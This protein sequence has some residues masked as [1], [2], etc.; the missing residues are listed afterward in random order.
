MREILRRPPELPSELCH[1]DRRELDDC[2]IDL[3]GVSDKKQRQKLL[4]E[5]YRETTEYYRYVRTQEIQAMVNR[6]GKKGRRL[7]P[8]DLAES[9]WNSLADTEK[10]PPIIEWIKSSCSHSEMVEI[11][12]GK[13]EALGAADMFNPT[14]V[15]F[16]G[17]KENHL[18]SY[19][20]ADQA[21]LVAELA[22]LEV[23]G[24][25]EVPK[26]ASECIACSE[27]LRDRLRDAENRFCELAASRTGTQSLQEKTSALLM[28]WYLHGRN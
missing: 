1:E 4:D 19:S 14:S 28:H 27:Q 17:S 16:K 23:R 7:G 24:N 11:P 21:A 2:V 15:N 26:S 9:I 3:I 13:P 20:S 8:Q 12:E 25:V 22:R 6:S 18:I 5:L 10:S